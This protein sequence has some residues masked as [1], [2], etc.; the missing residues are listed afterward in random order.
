VLTYRT[1]V[2]YIG[3]H[4]IGEERCTDDP[5]LE[6]LIV[7]LLLAKPLGTY[8]IFACMADCRIDGRIVVNL[9]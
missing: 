6:Y 7:L 4:G 8:D 3:R 1:I 5:G 2:R 9:Q